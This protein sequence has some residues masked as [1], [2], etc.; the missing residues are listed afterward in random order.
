MGYVSFPLWDFS[1]QIYIISSPS[2]K[3]VDEVTCCVLQ[4]DTLAICL[5]CCVNSNAL[6]KFLK[7]W[8]SIFSLRKPLFR[9]W[10]QNLWSAIFSSISEVTTLFRIETSLIGVF[11]KLP[12]ARGIYAC[13]TFIERLEKS[14]TEVIIAKNVACSSVLKQLEDGGNKLQSCKVYLTNF[15]FFLLKVPKI[16]GQAFSE[17]L[18]TCSAS[19]PATYP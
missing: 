10:D 5:A 6:D 18:N 16:L 14:S 2:F 4:H 8:V 11:N 7:R 13:P 12:Y 19:C 1:G 17:V 3:V 15:V 9:K